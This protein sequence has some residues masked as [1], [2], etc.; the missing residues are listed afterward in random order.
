VSLLPLSLYRRGRT[1]EGG[2]SSW[3]TLSCFPSLSLHLHADISGDF[4]LIRHVKGVI[5]LEE[6]EFGSSS[7]AELGVSAEEEED[8]WELLGMEDEEE[9]AAG[10]EVKPQG[11][12]WASIVGRS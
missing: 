8:E 1:I 11:K 9:G 10:K 2:R 12:S 7:S 6:D 3:L 4:E 5:A